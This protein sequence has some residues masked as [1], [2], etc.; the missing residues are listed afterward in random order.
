M[1]PSTL[2][3]HPKI[4]KHVVEVCELINNYKPEFILLMSF[5]REFRFTSEVPIRL[6]YHGKHMAME[7]VSYLLNPNVNKLY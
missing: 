6:D 1:C 3:I 7:Q 5:S 2:N 4:I